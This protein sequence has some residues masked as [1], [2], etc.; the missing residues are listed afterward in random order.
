MTSNYLNQ[1]AFFFFK[2]ILTDVENFNFSS[3]SNR[4]K[5]YTSTNLLNHNYLFGVFNYKIKKEETKITIPLSLKSIILRELRKDYPSYFFSI[6]LFECDLSRI[7]NVKYLSKLYTGG[8]RIFRN[9]EYYINNG[10]IIDSNHNIL[11]GWYG[12]YDITKKDLVS[13][14]IKTI[15]KILKVSPKVLKKED[16]LS[17]LFMTML[18]HI[19]EVNSYWDNIEIDLTNISIEITEDFS[20]YDNKIYKMNNYSFDKFNEA[21][22]KELR[23]AIINPEF[24]LND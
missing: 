7:E 12:N 24:L 22:N 4:E 15:K 18:P 20:F 9:T 16:P 19:K 8:K 10:F 3:S 6:P 14:E 13:N 17:K 21:A 5:C 23:R 11:F 2:R 1:L